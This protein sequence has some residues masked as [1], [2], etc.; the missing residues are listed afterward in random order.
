MSS[1]NSRPFMPSMKAVPQFH[2]CLKNQKIEEE[3]SFSSLISKL[4][5]GSVFA[6]GQTLRRTQGRS[7][8]R[9]NCSLGFP[10]WSGS[11]ALENHVQFGTETKTASV[12][13][14][15]SVGGVRYPE[16]WNCFMNRCSRQFGSFSLVKCRLKHWTAALEDWCYF[17]WF[18]LSPCWIVF[19][20]L[21]AYHHLLVKHS[22][23]GVEQVSQFKHH[24]D[25]GVVHGETPEKLRAGQL[26]LWGLGNASLKFLS[27]LP[28]S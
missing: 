2:L 13:R 11:Q 18:L 5:D 17:S 22:V 7:G 8:P 16:P 14:G 20:V 25:A 4:P 27:S 23:Q 3:S 1:A 6:P 26:K 15:R 19:G 12:C 24:Q 9:F 21:I 28:K 10:V